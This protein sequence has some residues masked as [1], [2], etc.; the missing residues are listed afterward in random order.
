MSKFIVFNLIL[1]LSL[2]QLFAQ[3]N[4]ILSVPFDQDT[5]ETKNPMF[6]WV[7]LDIAKTSNREYYRIIV[8]ELKNEQSAEAGIVVNQP[9]LI[10][11]PVKGNQLI[12]PY[13]AKELE[14]GHRYGWQVQK[15]KNSTIVNKSEAW[16]FTLWK[17]IEPQSYKYAQ[18]NTAPN[19]TIYQAT[20]GKVYFKYEDNHFSDDLEYYVYDE[21]QIAITS[22][23]DL[24]HDIDGDREVKVTKTNGAH[25]Y[26]LDLGSSA[27]PGV[28]TLTVLDAR[29]RKYSLTF[30]VL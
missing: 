12:Y 28:Y 5:I 19:G 10:I 27:K 18:L 3:D 17:P 9:L 26:V 15:I 7:Y 14:Y 20:D 23:L 13:D 6:S 2:N 21:N 1:F 25:H 8:V 29:K 16:E 4:I 24:D 30:R 22:K 11:E